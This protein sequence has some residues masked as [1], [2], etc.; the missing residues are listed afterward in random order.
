MQVWESQERPRS[1][2]A[3]STPAWVTASEYQDTASVMADKV[4][5]L[6]AL[7]KL[8]K[9]GFSIKRFDDLMNNSSIYKFKSRTMYSNPLI[10][11]SPNHQL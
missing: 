1:D 4:E 9:V 10:L 2:Q 11:S 3:A 6:A 7:L 5:R 8:S